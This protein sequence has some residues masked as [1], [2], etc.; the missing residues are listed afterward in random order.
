MTEATGRLSF[1]PELGP[2]T[3]VVSA[4]GSAGKLVFHRLSQPGS[5]GSFGFFPA[6]VGIIFCEYAAMNFRNRP[7]VTSY[8][9]SRK[10]LTVAGYALLA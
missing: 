6:P 10:L 8:L 3:E 2:L 5:F 7:T 9:S 4:A 1:D